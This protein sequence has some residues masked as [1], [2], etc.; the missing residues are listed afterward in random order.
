MHDALISD[1]ALIWA[2]VMAYPQKP[3][4]YF[5]ERG[6]SIYDAKETLLFRD[7]VDF[8]IQ[9]CAPQNRFRSSKRFY[10]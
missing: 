10:L 3:S 5:E 4:N 2:E 9:V 1:F 6:W 8:P 7:H